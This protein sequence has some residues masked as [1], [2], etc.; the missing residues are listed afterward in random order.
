MQILSE[1]LKEGFI[2]IRVETLDD[3]WHLCKILE[4]GDI[5]TGKTY[6]KITIKSGQEIKKGDREPVVL[7]IEA[8]KW[9]F[10]KDA[11]CLRI[12]GKIVSGP[13]DKVQIGSYH[14]IS[15]SPRTVLSIKKKWKSYQIERLKKAKI[16]KP[17]LLICVLDRDQAD[18]AEVKES[19]IDHLT[20]IYSKKYKDRDAMDEYRNEIMKYLLGKHETFGRII[21]A[22]P[23]FEK[24]NLFNHI[25]QKNPELARKLVIESAN[26]TGRTGI[27]EVI[28]SSANRIIK[29]TRIA[30]ETE[31]VERF[32]EEISKDGLAVY[33]AKETARAVESGAVETLLVSED[34]ISEFENIMEKAEKLGSRVVVIGTDHESGEKFL[35]LGGIGGL[36]RFKID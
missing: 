25:K 5:I 26:S 7:S 14:T 6:R 27:N 11:R 17:L 21:I 24:E 29:E 9:E 18:F 31:L 3:L 36:L 16:K 32:L 1:N 20:T 23:G 4:Q 28:R 33:G 19:G 22:G 30:T 15:V 35:S 34:K 13:E 10:Q 8:E 12:T 2:K